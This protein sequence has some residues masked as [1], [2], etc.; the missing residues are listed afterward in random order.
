MSVSRG[1]LSHNM[2]M[3][4]GYRS[5]LLILFHIRLESF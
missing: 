5:N 1:P 2:S 3:A 4:V